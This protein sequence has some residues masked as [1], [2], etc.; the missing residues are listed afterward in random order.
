MRGEG[1]WRLPVFTETRCRRAP[2]SCPWRTPSA[3]VSLPSVSASGAHFQLRTSRHG[4]RCSSPWWWRRKGVLE[5]ATF[6][7]KKNENE[8]EDIHLPT[9]SNEWR[10][11]A[12]P[13]RTK[14][15]RITF[16][17]SCWHP[18]NIILCLYLSISFAKFQLP[19]RFLHMS[20]KV[21]T[22]PFFLAHS[23]MTSGSGTIIPT[24]K[25]WK[26]QRN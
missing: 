22:M 2:Q 4:C 23:G 14:S 8:A 18:L 3:P 15:S 16:F 26:V 1:G 7:Y 6:L 10:P 24:K 20:L 9:C 12:L 21:P 11:L 5:N 19:T 17:K 13:R 25:D